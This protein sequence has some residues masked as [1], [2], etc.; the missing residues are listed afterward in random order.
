C[1][2]LY[3]GLP[4]HFPK[5]GGGVGRR[6]HGK[7]SRNEKRGL[8]MTTLAFHPL[9]KVFPLLEGEEFD[10]LMADI[11]PSGLCDAVWLYEGQIL[12]GRNGYRACQCLGRDCATRVYTGDNPLGFVI[13]M[14]VRRRH[15][16]ESQRAMIAAR[17]ANMPQGRPEKTPSIEGVSQETAAQLL[18]V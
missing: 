8:V 16:D 14:N 3:Q 6:R 13:S 12:D 1:G 2:G 7:N 11:Q 4:T 17:L 9:A 18:N 15:L 10:A 5:A